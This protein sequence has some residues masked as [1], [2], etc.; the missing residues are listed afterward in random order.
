MNQKQ[1][2]QLIDYLADKSLS[3]GCECEFIDYDG[4][5]E[6]AKISW[7]RNE[8]KKF[9]TNNVCISIESHDINKILGHP[10]RI[11]DV[12]NKLYEYVQPASIER[13]Y[14]FEE[15]HTPD[16]IVRLW[17]VKNFKKSLQELANEGMEM[18]DS[19]PHGMGADYEITN[20]DIKKLFE[21]LW[22]IFEDELNH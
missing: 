8:D 3:F 11:G 9:D 18:T 15:P 5:I 19:C 13:G 4:E 22:G 16:N 6:C 7:Y 12:L 20:P 14:Y 2:E 21:F 1:V 17:G 10:I